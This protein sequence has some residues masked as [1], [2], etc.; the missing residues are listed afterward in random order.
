MYIRHQSRFKPNYST[1]DVLIR[2]SDDWRKGM[3]DY[4]IIGALLFYRSKAY[5]MIDH[6]LLLKEMKLEFGIVG[7]V[8][9]RFHIYLRK[10]KMPEGVSSR[11]FH[12][13]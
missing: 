3:D 12:L 13:G 2:T 8:Y 5:D 11:Q 7:K 4:H 1:Q 10:W 6:E 9:E